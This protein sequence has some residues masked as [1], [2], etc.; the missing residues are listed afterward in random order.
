MLMWEDCAL[1]LMGCIFT[2]EELVTRI[3]SSHQHSTDISGGG[4]GGGGNGSCCNA[5]HSNIQNSLRYNS[6]LLQIGICCC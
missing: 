1:Q 4:G 6:C 3:T 5:V 2:P